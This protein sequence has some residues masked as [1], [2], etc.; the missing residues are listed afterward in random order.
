[1]ALG[2]HALQ[3]SADI[4]PNFSERK[5]SLGC[6]CRGPAYWTPSN[7]YQNSYLNL[8]LVQTAHWPWYIALGGT[9][10][11]GAATQAWAIFLARFPRAA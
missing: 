3:R 11:S 1:M 5:K 4:R 7:S 2:I 10:G 8:Y 6:R 9:N